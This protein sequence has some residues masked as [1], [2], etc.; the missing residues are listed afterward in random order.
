MLVGITQ[1][2]PPHTFVFSVRG[3][4]ENKKLFPKKEESHSSVFHMASRQL[5]ERESCICSENTLKGLSVNGVVKFLGLTA[6][7]RLISRGGSNGLES[8]DSVKL[9]L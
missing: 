3:C 4:I 8:R 9:S 7:G 2:V 6:H 5:V 1:I